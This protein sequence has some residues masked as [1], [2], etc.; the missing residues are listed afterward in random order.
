MPKE[1]TN[2]TPKSWYSQYSRVYEEEE[3]KPSKSALPTAR[4]LGELE[5]EKNVRQLAYFAEQKEAR[6]KAKAQKS[7]TGKSRKKTRGTRKRSKK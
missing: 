2:R 3:D 4:R 1:P 5:I 7:S 6:E